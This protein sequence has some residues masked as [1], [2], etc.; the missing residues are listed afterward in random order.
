MISPRTA[1]SGRITSNSHWSTT[2]TTKERVYKIL[3]SAFGTPVDSLSDE[4]GPDTIDAWD[5]L[6]HVNLVLALESEF[7]ITLSDDDVNN[8]LSVGLVGRVVENRMGGGSP[9]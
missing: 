7:G 1:R 5:S 4:D 3:S 9:T 8:M 6:S 2:L